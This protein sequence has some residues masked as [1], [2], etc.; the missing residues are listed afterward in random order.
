MEKESSMNQESELEAFLKF[1]RYVR[2]GCPEVKQE[3]IVKAWFGWLY[4][5][6]ADQLGLTKEQEDILDDRS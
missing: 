4:E 5:G 3:T 1:W 2:E 6:G